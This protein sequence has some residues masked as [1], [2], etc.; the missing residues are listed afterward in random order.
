MLRKT[1]FKLFIPSL[2]SVDNIGFISNYR[3]HTS[4]GTKNGF[5]SNS[6]TIKVKSVTLED[7]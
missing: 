2:V 4:C 6:C 5:I 3:G 7:E 1:N